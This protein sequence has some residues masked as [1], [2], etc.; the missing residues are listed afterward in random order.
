MGHAFRVSRCLLQS[1]R[2]RM[3]HQQPPRGL[4]PCSPRQLPATSRWYVSPIAYQ[5]TEGLRLVHGTHCA[6]TAFTPRPLTC[7][8]FWHAL[9]TPPLQ[10]TSN[11]VLAVQAA[12]DADAE[13]AYARVGALCQAIKA[14]LN[15]DLKIH[16]QGILPPFINLPQ[17]TGGEYSR[18]RPTVPIIN[19]APGS[20]SCSGPQ[21]TGAAVAMHLD[22]LNNVEV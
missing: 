10:G 13:V 12:A 1:V 8:H 14:E 22:G 15:N 17:V 9:D 7:F 18:V 19:K 11:A 16:D 4:A 3:S 5:T 20:L 2:R 21:V 6:Y